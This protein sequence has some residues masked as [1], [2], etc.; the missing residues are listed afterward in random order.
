MSEQTIA[1]KKNLIQIYAV[2]GG[3]TSVA[4]QFEPFRGRKEDGFAELSIAY[5]DTSTSD[6]SDT[7]PANQFYHIK[8]SDDTDGSGQVRRE[9]A[10]EIQARVP[11]I[12]QTHKPG[13]FNIVI[14]TLAGGSGS[15]IGPSL[16]SE[17]IERGHPTI[18]I[19]IGATDTVLKVRN[20]LYTLKSYDGVVKVRKQ[21][22]TLAYYQNEKGNKTAEVDRN[23]YDLVTSLTALFSN[24][25]K[26]LDMQDLKNWL[27]YTK[28]SSFDPAL[29]ALSVINGNTIHDPQANFGNVITV[30]TLATPEA[31]TAFPMEQLPDYQVIGLIP[32]SIAKTAG[33]TTPAHFFTSDGVIHQVVSR[34][35]DII[36]SSEAAA[37]ARLHQKGA[38]N[39][40]DRPADNGLVL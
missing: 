1:R 25:N 17:L 37:G 9:L 2:G 11:N 26:G 13:D 15:V 3:G 6:L 4:T 40:N 7:V 20:T 28:V 14:G 12:L 22:V 32:D 10:G 38:L 19:G 16:V 8:T 27:N 30:A 5:V 29:V 36:K 21:P 39:E 31:N 23:V 24:Q 34:L 33:S 18:V 35:E